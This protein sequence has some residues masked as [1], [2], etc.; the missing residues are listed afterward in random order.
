MTDLVDIDFDLDRY[1]ADDG[2]LYDIGFVSMA[3]F[4]EWQPD[5]SPEVVRYRLERWARYVS[6]M[7]KQLTARGAPLSED[8]LQ[9]IWKDA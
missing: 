4:K 9:Q 7:L 5:V 3:R 2:K 8:E 1:I 6:E